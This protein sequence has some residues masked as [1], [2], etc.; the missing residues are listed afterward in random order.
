[1]EPLQID[2][3]CSRTKQIILTELDSMG[4]YWRP[5]F[6]SFCWAHFDDARYVFS[7]TITHRE[8]PLVKFGM[9]A[10]VDTLY[11]D[12]DAFYDL[13]SK[14]TVHLHNEITKTM[15]DGFLMAAN[16]N[17]Y[18]RAVRNYECI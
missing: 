8:I 16:D 14:N 5:L 2:S 13:V 10:S 3:I 15:S 6:E 11:N 18:G 9:T 7:F 12:I 17:A 4:T 1:M